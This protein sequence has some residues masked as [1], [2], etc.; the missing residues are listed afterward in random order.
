MTFTFDLKKLKVNNTPFTQKLEMDRL[1][2]V[3]RPQSGALMNT[4]FCKHI[5]IGKIKFT[6][7]LSLD[8]LST[9]LK[10]YTPCTT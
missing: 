3:G 8:L 1:I 5:L 6:Q 7:K 9:A 2:T 10:A 4:F